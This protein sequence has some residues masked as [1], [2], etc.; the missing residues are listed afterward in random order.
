M[1]D[2]I[3]RKA[4]AYYEEKKNEAKEFFDR[5]ESGEKIL[6]VGKGIVE[7]INQISSTSCSMISGA[8]S[9]TIM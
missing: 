2:G 7:A 8:S 9:C 5:P 1:A 3:R 6:K 4:R